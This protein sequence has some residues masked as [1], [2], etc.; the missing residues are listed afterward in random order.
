[1]IPKELLVL[2]LSISVSVSTYAIPAS[3]QGN[4]HNAVCL[5]KTKALAHVCKELR[6]LK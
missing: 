2:G 4:L 1:M 3:W 5:C 6:D